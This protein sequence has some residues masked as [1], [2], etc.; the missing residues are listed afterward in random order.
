LLSLTD[1]EFEKFLL[2]KW[3]YAGQQDIEKHVGL[4]S[5]DISLLQIHGCIQKENIIMFINPSCKK[6]LINVN[7][8]KKL[9]LPAKHIETA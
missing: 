7:L 2:D 5:T 6:N 3:S 4:F 1:E 8:E 9:Q